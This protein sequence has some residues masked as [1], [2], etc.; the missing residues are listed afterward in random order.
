MGKAG[1][2]LL[3]AFQLVMVMFMGYQCSNT[4]SEP[5]NPSNDTP[6]GKVN[7]T[8]K[9]PITI[10]DTPKIPVAVIDTS[11]TISIYE[12]VDS[13]RAHLS[14]EE[15]ERY[16]DTI[17][18]DATGQELKTQYYDRKLLFI[19][20]L[21]DNRYDWE[22]VSDNT[23]PYS[24]TITP[25]GRFN[26]VFPAH[27]KTSYNETWLQI[28][29]TIATILNSEPS[30]EF[31][32][33]WSVEQFPDSF[34]L[35][36][37][38][39]GD[40]NNQ[41]KGC[42]NPDYSKILIVGNRNKIR[43]T[44]SRTDNCGKDFKFKLNGRWVL[45]RD[46]GQLNKVNQL[47]IRKETNTWTVLVNNMMVLSFQYFGD[48]NLEQICFGRGNYIFKEFK[49]VRATFHTTIEKTISS[50]YQKVVQT[51]KPK[52]WILLAAVEDYTYGPKPLKYTV[53]DA[54]S[55]YQFWTGKSGGKIPDNQIVI[56]LNEKATKE[57]ILAKANILFAKAA[58][59]DNL[60]V[61]LSGHGS[62]GSFL[63]YNGDLP[64]SKLNKILS[65]SKAKKKLYFI[66]ACHAGSIT[67]KNAEVPGKP[68]LST[69][70]AIRFYY[71]Q[72]NS[73]K[74]E[75][76]YFLSCKANQLSQELN[77]LG[78]GVFTYSLREAVNGG[79]DFDSDGI[80]NLSEA[81]SFVSLK[82]KELNPR[83][84]PFT[85]GNFDKESPITAK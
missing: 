45:L 63:T 78:H 36:F 73:K 57:K 75:I 17:S 54:I 14:P 2:C 79:A 85:T 48:M 20:S 55:L 44:F 5:I 9:L 30:V 18:D 59:D 19:D 52:T 40:L 83:Q 8:P 84:T 4:G 11:H 21:R 64:Y 47:R 23:S 26:C 41:I 67:G 71:S 43:S 70:D 50:L 39:D 35:G 74:D 76:G 16:C 42:E 33:K 6:A 58:P 37:F 1:K 3:A 72:M 61:F 81:D 27:S 56:L 22:L 7:D 82:V 25:G 46:S 34:L 12:N 80:I 32:V 31:E 66:D 10:I 24:A 53:D 38:F 49:V 69:K 77:R 65:L 28:P 29:D 62:V 60:I 51:S 15:F 68:D 13:A